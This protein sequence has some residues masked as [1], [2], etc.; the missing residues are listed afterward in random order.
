MFGL[1]VLT[2]HHCCT[3][4]YAARLCSRDPL[5]RRQDGHLQF[6]LRRHGEQ[7]TWLTHLR[8]SAYH[9]WQHIT[10][11]GT[12]WSNTVCT[13]WSLLGCK[14]AAAHLVNTFW[15]LCHTHELVTANKTSLL[16]TAEGKLISIFRVY[17]LTTPQVYGS[18]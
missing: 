4:V 7:Q 14:T 18:C 13:L 10:A 9:C 11:N 6:L 5:K 16:T 2:T 15:A 8:V 17:T 1:S 12:F 3:A